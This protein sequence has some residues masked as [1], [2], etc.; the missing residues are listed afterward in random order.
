VAHHG[1]GAASE[2]VDV[3][4]V[5]SRGFVDSAVRASR[6]NAQ[7]RTVDPPTTSQSNVRSRAPTKSIKNQ[8]PA[9]A[10]QANPSVLYQR[11]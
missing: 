8:N 6:K 2:T 3:V 10:S 9:K 5:G 11:R 1:S 4:N 7:P